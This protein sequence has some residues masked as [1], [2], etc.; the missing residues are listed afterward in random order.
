MEAWN[1][2]ESDPEVFTNLIHK[3]GVNGVQAKE[4]H[5]MDQFLED[6]KNQVYGLIFCFK[7]ENRKDTQLEENYTSD[8]NIYFPQQII[9]N[10]CATQAILSI[11]F[12]NKKIELG[13]DLTQFKEFSLDFPADLKGEM[14]GSSDLIRNTHN[15]FSGS[16][17]FISQ[18]YKEHLN[19]VYKDRPKEDAF[20]FS[21]FLP[22]NNQLFELDGLKRGPIE[23]GPINNEN[24]VIQAFDIIRKK[25]ESYGGAEL[26][27]NLMAITEDEI[28]I[29]KKKIQLLENQ[30]MENPNESVLQYQLIELKDQLEYSD[31]L[32]QKSKVNL[33]IS[34]HN[35]IP[36]LFNVLGEAAKNNRLGPILEKSNKKE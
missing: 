27:F 17:D 13:A 21:S 12:N 24:W 16:D 15:S 9:T 19:E 2:I 35:F 23:H 36:F 11:L 7:W 6:E 8:Q 34:S 20:H 18:W 22:I 10:A 14:I 33:D 32:R 5:I 30:L 25:I 3:L 29:L 4:I 28:D 31:R 26:R 1:L